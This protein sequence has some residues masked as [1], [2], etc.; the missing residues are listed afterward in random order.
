MTPSINR[1][2]GGLMTTALA[3]LLLLSG[4]AASAGDAATV[5]IDV[6]DGVLRTAGAECAGGGEFRMLHP[7]AAYEIVSPE[8]DVLDTG[9]LP[10]G[11]AEKSFTPDFEGLYEPTFCRMEF[12]VTA[13]GSLDGFTLRVDGHTDIR[14]VD[15]PDDENPP[16]AMVP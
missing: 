5:R 1:R 8:G 14:I 13:S 2:G 6:K 15:D 4:C 7:N 11:T 3:A 16:T 12:E 9:V 10:H